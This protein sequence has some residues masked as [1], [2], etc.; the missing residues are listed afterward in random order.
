MDQIAHLL[1]IHQMKGTQFYEKILG[2][3]QGT[4]HRIMPLYSGLSFKEWRNQYVMLSAKEWLVETDYK[5]D[6]IGKRLGFSGV[7]SF[8]KWFI[9]TEKDLPIYWRQR[10]QNARKRQEAE[11]VLQWKKENYTKTRNEI[12]LP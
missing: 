10:T 11:Q 2:V 6:V 7:H 8:S 4:L 5:L 9:R 12:Q 1:S 3:P